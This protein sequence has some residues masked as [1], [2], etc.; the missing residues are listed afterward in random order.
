M[1]NEVELFSSTEA[2]LVKSEGDFVDGTSAGDEDNKLYE[3]MF[4]DLG[5]E[6]MP[7]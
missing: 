5:S 7:C 1:A 2:K 4:V 6:K 3:L